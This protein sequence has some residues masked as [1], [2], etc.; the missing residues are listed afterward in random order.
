MVT[1]FFGVGKV[2]VCVVKSGAGILEFWGF[3]MMRC[4]D[5][6]WVVFWLSCKL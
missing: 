1:H 3:S 2:I 5:V 6:K 4:G